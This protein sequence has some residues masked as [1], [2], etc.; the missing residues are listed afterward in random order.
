MLDPVDVFLLDDAVGVAKDPGAF[1][2]AIA[3]EESSFIGF[4]GGRTNFGVVIQ[5][6]CLQRSQLASEAAR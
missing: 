3:E 2:D 5:V 1:G 6:Q 4:F